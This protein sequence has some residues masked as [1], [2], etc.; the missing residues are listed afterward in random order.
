[1]ADYIIVDSTALGGSCY[2]TRLLMFAEDTRVA[3][4][5]PA[6]RWPRH[7][8]TSPTSMLGTL[9][10]V[11]ALS[12]VM[13]WAKDGRANF[14]QRDAFPQERG[15]IIVGRLFW[16]L[17]ATIRKGSKVF[18]NF[19]KLRGIWRV[20]YTR[21]GMARI[22]LY[23]RHHESRRET[24]PLHTLQHLQQS[25]AV[26]SINGC[27]LAITSFN[28]GPQGNGR[29][30]ILDDRLGPRFVRILTAR[31]CW[32]L[33]LCPKML[34]CGQQRL[35]PQEMGDLAGACITQPMAKFMATS[36]A[37]RVS[38]LQCALHT[39]PV[40]SDLNVKQI[41]AM[42]LP[43]SLSSQKCLLEKQGRYIG[44]PA[45][46]RASARNLVTEYHKC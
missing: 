20:V 9:E 37:N 14:E 26:Y 30:F 40:I 11:A 15:A 44:A 38:Q 43:I 16:G 33:N 22:M 41:H 19:A 8:L 5:L 34:P 17:G 28:E 21:N 31:E 12:D 32:N 39:L 2:R 10:P 1:M 18:C 27:A 4:Q 6:F 24:V 42:L 13:D 46:D 3:A 25:F 29:I 23:N 36:A 35:T 45:K 7:L